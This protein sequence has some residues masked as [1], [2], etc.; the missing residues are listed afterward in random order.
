MKRKV[1]MKIRKFSRRRLFMLIIA[2][3][4]FT[5]LVSVAETNLNDLD[6]RLSGTVILGDLVEYAYR[7]NPSIWEAREAWRATIE[8]YRLETAYPDPEIMMTY[9]PDPL[10]TRLGPQDWNANLTQKIPFPGKLSKAGEV[11]EAE[12]RIAKLNVDKTIRDIIVSI[13]ESFYELSYIRQAQTA[14]D[15]NLKLLDHLRKISETAYAQDRNTLLDMV[16]AQS[17]S[18]QL[19]Y[20]ILLLRDLEETEMAQLNSLLNRQTDAPFGRLEVEIDQSVVFSLDEIYQLAETHQEEIQMAK[21]QIERSK[22]KI[23]LA[24]FQNLPDFKVGLFYAGIGNPDV[25]NPPPNAGDD[26]LGIQTGITIPLWFGKN[27][28]RVLKAKAEMKRAEAAKTARVNETSAKIRSFYFRLENA[29]RLIEL[30]SKELL[31]QAAKSMEI[32]ETWYQEGQSSFSDFIETQSVWY[33]FQ[34]ALARAKA[35]YGK[36]LARLERLVGKSITIRQADH[37]MK[38]EGK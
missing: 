25:A 6:A 23:E 17:Q 9:F 29:R 8:Q 15:Q 14:A 13:R 37:G 20:D 5:P 7:N 30:Y 1:D 2:G 10:E 34:L 31:P 22:R 3:L 24:K 33:N 32:A 38:K 36:N 11:V 16:K 21:V 27:K 12:A 35:D 4:F 19:R 26:A 28:S 18:G